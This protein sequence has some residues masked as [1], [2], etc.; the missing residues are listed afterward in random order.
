MPEMVRL[1]YMFEV[2]IEGSWY[3]ERACQQNHCCMNHG[4]QDLAAVL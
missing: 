1:A 4:K 3:F 2:E